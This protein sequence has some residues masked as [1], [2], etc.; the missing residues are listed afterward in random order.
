[1]FLSKGFQAFL[2]KPIDCALMDAAIRQWVRDKQQEAAWFEEN[3]DEEHDGEEPRDDEEAPSASDAPAHPSESLRVEGIDIPAAFLRFGANEGLLLEELRSYVRNVP[4]LLERLRAAFG[5]GAEGLP[6]YAIAVHAMKGSSRSICA[7]LLGSQ[8]EVLEYA[9]KGGDLA[10]VQAHNGD[11][12]E[13]ADKLIASLRVALRMDEAERAKPRKAAP[14]AATLA[15]LRAACGKLDIDGADQAMEE[16][17]RYAYQTGGDLVEWLRL[18]VDK[19]GFQQ[20]LERL[21]L[22]PLIQERPPDDAA[23]QGEAQP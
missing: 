2:S 16:L 1:M 13:A 10:F 15:A 19:V 18:Q 14:D 5:E 21:T 7:R 8:A 20:I 23:S 9:A 17:E 12:V 6:A 22:E 4:S 11:F 3:G